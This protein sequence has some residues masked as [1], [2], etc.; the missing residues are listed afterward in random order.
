[1]DLTSKRHFS[2]LYVKS[3]L[4]LSPPVFW[5]PH[6]S[7]SKSYC[8]SSSHC[9]PLHVI[10]LPLKMKKRLFGPS[11]TIF[12]SNNLQASVRCLL[13][14]VLKKKRFKYLIVITLFYMGFKLQLKGWKS[15]N[16]KLKTKKQKMT[17]SLIWKKW[18]VPDWSFFA[19]PPDYLIGQ[20]DSVT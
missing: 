1:M 8:A 17:A 18:Q 20:A 14:C 2:S 12:W 15:D 6:D 13:F 16:L 11:T 19:L 7:G 5:I 3:K 4:P 9:W 10:W